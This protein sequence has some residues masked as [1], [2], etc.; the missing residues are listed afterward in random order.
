[1]KILGGSNHSGEIEIRTGIQ[2]RHHGNTPTGLLA[3]DITPAYLSYDRVGDN[4]IF[5]GYIGS[6]SKY[7]IKDNVHIVADV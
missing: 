5:G 7:E 1:M 3:T 6:H 2:Y 4:N